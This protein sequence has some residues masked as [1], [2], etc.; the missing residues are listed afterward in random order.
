[1]SNQTASGVAC[2][3]RIVLS[4]TVLSL[5][6]CAG[7]NSGLVEKN[8]GKA[9]RQIMSSQISNQDAPDQDQAPIDGTDSITAEI[10]VENYKTDVERSKEEAK[11]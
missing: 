5:L 9:Y 11:D 6:G 1:M 10:V 3:G 8:W 2:F 7:K 4:L